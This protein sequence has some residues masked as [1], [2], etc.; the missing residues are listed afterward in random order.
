MCMNKVTN[1]FCCCIFT[2]IASLLAAAGIAALFFGSLISSVTTLLIVTLVVGILSLI[3][4]LFTAFCGGKCLCKQ[5]L[6]SCLLT[7]SV[8]SIVTSVFALTATSLAVSLPTAILIGV[9]AFFL[10]SNLITLIN[11]IVSNLCNDKCHD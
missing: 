6:D 8:G 10:V 3:Y 2:I 5:L 9:V 7:T 1:N 4:I 11:I